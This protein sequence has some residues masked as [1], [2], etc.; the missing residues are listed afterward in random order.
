MASLR[1][2]TVELPS[3]MPMVYLPLSAFPP[4]PSSVH[5]MDAAFSPQYGSEAYFTLIPLA[6]L[7]RNPPKYCHCFGFRYF[8]DI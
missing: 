2:L 7:P 3:L 5:A 8:A 1:T 6:L 4:R